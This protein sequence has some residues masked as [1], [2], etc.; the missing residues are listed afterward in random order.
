MGTYDFKAWQELAWAAGVAALTFGLTV[1]VTF[2]PE[3][4]TDWRAWAISLGAGAIRAAA[5]ALIPQPR[6]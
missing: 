4:I 6:T 2:D 5:G 1:L 3:T